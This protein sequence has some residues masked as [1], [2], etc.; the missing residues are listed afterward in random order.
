MS[1]IPQLQ[2]LLNSHRDGTKYV[3]ITRGSLLWFKVSLT[4]APDLANRLIDIYEQ[5]NQ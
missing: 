1:G 5:D 2:V 3:A 4:E